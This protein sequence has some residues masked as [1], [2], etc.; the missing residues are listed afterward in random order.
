MNSKTRTLMQVKTLFTIADSLTPNASRPEGNSQRGQ[1]LSN[2]I[3]DGGRSW[4]THTHTHTGQ[5]DD[6]DDGEHV[7]VLRQHAGGFHG[8][9]LSAEVLDA[10]PDQ[11]VEGGA[12]R[13]RHA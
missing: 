3:E 6:D 9:V 7:W 5:S 2:N 8:H 1:S 11:L 4:E 12:P 13:T 10:P